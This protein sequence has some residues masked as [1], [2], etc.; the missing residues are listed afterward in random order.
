MNA[1]KSSGKRISLM[2]IQK[3]FFRT[4]LVLILSLA[5]ILGV[6]GTLINIHFETHKRDQNLQ[7]V[8][9]AIAQ[10]P[11]LTGRGSAGME[12]REIFS[13]YLDTLRDTLDDIDVIS[14]VN[15]DAVRIYHSNHALIGTEYDGNMPDFKS[16]TDG[17]Y[18]VNESGPSGSQRRA[19]AAV[20]NESGEYVGVVMAIM[21]MKNIKTET[22]QMLLIFLVITVVAVLIELIVAGKLSGKVK[23][24]LM[25][26]EPD[27]FTAM[28]KMR[29]NILETLA[30]G[31][32]A[33]DTNGVIQFA[34][35]SAIR[36][37]FDHPMNNLV[38]Q[39][40]D[41]IGDEILSR[42]IKSGGKERNI[43]LTKADIILDRVPIR[44]D[45]GTVGAIAVLHNR[46]E[47]TKL[48]EELSG[49][50]YL[51][52]SMRAN[53]HDFTNKL[54]VILGLIQMGMYDDASSYIQN[55]TMVQRENISKVMNAVG[56]PA[57][58]ALLIGKIARASELNVNFVLREG[59]Y[60]SPADMHL[61]AEMLITVIGNLLDNA[62]DAMNESTDYKAHKELM[63]G[64]YS[65]PGAVLITVD[66]TGSGI[67]SENMEFLF[68][69]GFSTKGEGRGTGLCQV[70]SMVENF[71]GKIT[72]E[73]QEGVGTSFSVSFT[74]ENKNV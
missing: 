32:L 66:D 2:G 55:I 67:K 25:G 69:N 42:S 51:V 10:S 38:G 29:D 54:H 27:V 7:N 8:A 6:A 31:I 3:L 47:Y 74:K 34:N 59:C 68:D 15:K 22:A 44:E 17:Y 12:D 5:L 36:M 43:N 73:S 13:E 37:L 71:D 21:L 40:V 53:N 58:A 20:Y 64:I 39:S 30:E 61:P 16:H 11:M 52:D 49:T 60:Y 9:E 72:V 18:A 23:K 14:V 35:E 24:S 26:Y 45:G 63:F 62:F 56:E 65:K 28:Y 57:V 4:Q 50:R 19:Y 46:A 33:F 48:M 41:V 1:Q 70:K